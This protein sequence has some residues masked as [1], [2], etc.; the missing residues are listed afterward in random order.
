MGQHWRQSHIQS[1]LAKGKQALGAVA[2]GSPNEL[3][4]VRK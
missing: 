2:P 1:S 3:N 4:K